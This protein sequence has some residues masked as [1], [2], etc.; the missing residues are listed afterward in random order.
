M[1]FFPHDE[2]PP[3]SL[4]TT[5]ATFLSHHES[6]TSFIG[7]GTATRETKAAFVRT[8]LAAV[9]SGGDQVVVKALTC[10]RI[11]SREPN[12]CQDLFLR[13]G[14]CALL[15]QAHLTASGSAYTE[16]PVVVEALKC[17]CNVLLQHPP[18]RGTVRESGGVGVIARILKEQN[19]ALPPDSQFLFL[20]LLFLLTVDDQT[21]VAELVDPAV[22]L[23]ATLVTLMHRPSGTDIKAPPAA[24]LSEIMKTIYNLMSVGQT[25]V[26]QRNSGTQM[27]VTL[28]NTE[29]DMEWVAKFQNLLPEIINLLLSCDATLPLSPPLSH[30]IHTLLNFP[31]TPYRSVFTDARGSELVQRLC[32]ILGRTLG[33]ENPRSASPT[34]TNLDEVVPPLIIVLSGIARQDLAAREEMRRILLPD[35]I[36]RSKPLDQGTSITSQLIAF[37]TALA[38]PNVRESVCDLIFVL[39]DENA[40]KLVKYTGYGHAAGFLY[41]KGLLSAPTGSGG[42]GGGGGDHAP[43]VVGGRPHYATNVDPIT[44]EYEKHAAGEND[45]DGMTEAEKEE[46]AEKLMVLFQRL[47]KTGVIKAVVPGMQE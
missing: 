6:T 47:N 31:L 3:Q 32:A 34:T 14:I 9:E 42:G 37:M 36:D 25:T 12:G 21:T 29:V 22:D 26:P 4:S 20:R 45:W 38:V 11:L 44:G 28:A 10:L 30:T 16:T 2:I 46:E 35:D 27:V 17:L 18:A 41:A 39:S 40:E 1:A 23:P 24:L 43:I 5:L 8:L 13:Q 15:K 7:A 33:S 19:T